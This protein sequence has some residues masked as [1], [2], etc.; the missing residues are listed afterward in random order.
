MDGHTGV[1]SLSF[2]N[3]L[4]MLNDEWGVYRSQSFNTRK[5]VDYN[6][7]ASTGVYTYS[8]PFGQSG[9]ETANWDRVSA[10]RSVWQVKLGLR[11]NF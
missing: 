5:L 3:V 1:V 11:Y 10:E 7:D 2:V 6:Y 4:N 9:L 8:V